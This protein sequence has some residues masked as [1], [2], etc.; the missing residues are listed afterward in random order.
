V[1]YLF[2]AGHRDSDSTLADAMPPFLCV[3]LRLLRQGDSESDAKSE[4][5]LL[6]TLVGAAAAVL[7][8][9]FIGVVTRREL[10]RLQALQAQHL[11][12]STSPHSFLDDALD[13]SVGLHNSSI[14]VDSDSVSVG[15]DEDA[16]GA[17]G[18][19]QEARL[20]VLRCAHTTVTMCS[21]TAS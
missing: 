3:C 18:T 13:E 11:P 8:M 16:M 5:G 15:V 17:G 19:A 14:S 12:L 20:R 1:L 21:R 10:Q 2:T 6:L 9:V 7:L 4:L